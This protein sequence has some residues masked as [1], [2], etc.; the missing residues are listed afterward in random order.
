MDKIILLIISLLS[1][2]S[3][4]R[5]GNNSYPTLQSSLSFLMPHLFD[6][7]SNTFGPTIH[8]FRAIP[9]DVYYNVT[10]DTKPMEEF[11]NLLNITGLNLRDVHIVR[12]FPFFSL[13]N[14]TNASTTAPTNVSDESVTI[15]TSDF[16][17]TE[18][19]TLKSRPPV[20]EVVN[21]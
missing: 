1:S 21:N 13:N 11:I 19:Y 20:L 4:Q 17:P 2:A 10:T 15:N 5:D 12:A 3:A 16:E 9:A 6:N 7:I 18:D 8:Y 14:S